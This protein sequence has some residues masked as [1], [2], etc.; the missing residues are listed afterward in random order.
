MMQRTDLRY[1]MDDPRD[2]DACNAALKAWADSL[3]VAEPGDWPGDALHRH[4][5][6]RCRAILATV[7]LAD[8]GKC[9]VNTEALREKGL[10]ENSAQWIAAHWLAEYNALKQ[11][12]ERLEAG[13]VTP[14]NLSRMLM[15]AEEMGRLQERMWWRAGV[16]PISGEK[17]EALALT[18]RPV[19]RGQKDG[20]AITNKAH[21]AMREARF[22]RMKELVP[23]LG[24]ENAARQCE[25]EGLGG[26]QAI[27]RQW[28]RYR[29]KNTDTRATVRQNM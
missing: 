15:A 4:N 10:A 6:E 20:A 22:A 28:D 27:R 9:V 3:P 23:D 5:A 11:G 1:R 21:A 29:E 8:D 24:V 13:D 2:V 26:W 12:R 7:D 19:K 18:G 16:D 17:R 14:E 25:A